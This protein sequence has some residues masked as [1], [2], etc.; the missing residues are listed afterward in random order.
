MHLSDWTAAPVETTDTPNLPAIKRNLGTAF[1]DI[2][3]KPLTAC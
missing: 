3:L 1:V 2:G